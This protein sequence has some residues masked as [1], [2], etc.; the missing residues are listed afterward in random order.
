MMEEKNLSVWSTD[1]DGARQE[2]LA[3]H[4]E[5]RKKNK[6]RIRAYDRYRYERD[7]IEVGAAAREKKRN[8]AREWKKRN[9][10]KAR[11]KN[12]K[13]WLARKEVMAKMSK[14]KRAIFNFH[15][16]EL[17]KKSGVHSK[18]RNYKKHHLELLIAGRKRRADLTDGYLRQTLTK[19]THLDPADIPQDLLEV[20]RIHLTLKREVRQCL[21]QSQKT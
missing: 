6:E 5:Y 8:Y 19:K 7:V 15:R 1:T 16:R 14:E 17:Y 11:L 4:K 20:K 12:I 13:T 2:R 3:Y 21:K 18:A 9:P 10:E